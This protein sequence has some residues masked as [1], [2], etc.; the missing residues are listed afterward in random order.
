M[1]TTTV[2]LAAKAVDARTYSHRALV[3]RAEVI[4]E[5]RASFHLED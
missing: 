3:E 1:N 2:E 5:E 4:S